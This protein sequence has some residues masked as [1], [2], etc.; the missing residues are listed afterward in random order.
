FSFHHFANVVFESSLWKKCCFVHNLVLSKDK[1]RIFMAAVSSAASAVSSASKADKFGPGTWGPRTSVE[2]FFKQIPKEH[3]GILTKELIGKAKEVSLDVLMQITGGAAHQA[4]Q[5]SMHG[6]RPDAAKMEA[7]FIR[8]MS[9][10]GTYGLAVR[11]APV[12]RYDV[13]Y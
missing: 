13:K 3:Q 1:R 12:H 2:A 7:P 5:S 8:S 4:W 6:R 9:S 10:A 11:V